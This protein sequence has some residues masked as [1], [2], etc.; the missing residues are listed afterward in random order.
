EPPVAE[1]A[2]QLEPAHPRDPDVEHQQVVLA[3]G[4]EPERLEAVAHQVGVEAVLLEPPLD[5]LADGLVVLHHEDLHAASARAGRNTWKVEPLPTWLSASMR[6][7]WSSM[8]P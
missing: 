4:G 1:R 8:I 5:V 6:P 3:A 7:R 2:D